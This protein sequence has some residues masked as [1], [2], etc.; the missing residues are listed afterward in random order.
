MMNIS[1][2]T[3]RFC[4]LSADYDVRMNVSLDGGRTAPPADQG[5][6]VAGGRSIAD[7]PVDRDQL[8]EDLRSLG[9]RPGQDLLI[10]CSLRRIGPVDGG[11]ATLLDAIRDVAGPAATLVVPAQTTWNS[12]TS[13][14]FRAATAGLDPASYA[15]YVA[16]MPGFDPA[17]TPSSGMG[18]FAEYVRTRPG[19]CRSAHPQ[20][21][22]AA[23]GPRAAAAMSEHDLDCHFG[24]RSPLRWLYDADAAILLL[25]VDY[26]ACTAFHLAEYRLPRKQMQTYCCFTVSGGTRTAHEFTDIDLD[27]SDF[28]LIG[29]VLNTATW[30][31][32]DDAP[33]SGRVGM[34]ACTLVH[35]R[36]AV[37]FACSWMNEHR[38]ISARQLHACAL[39]PHRSIVTMALA[40]MGGRW[41]VRCSIARC[42][43]SPA[44][45]PQATTGTRWWSGSTATPAQTLPRSSSCRTVPTWESWTALDC[46]AA[47][48][49]LLNQY[50]LSVP[51]GCLLPC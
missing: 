47:S 29:T 21:S 4:G 33:R 1:R 19:A 46:G 5:G 50:A 40:L 17:T 41:D 37:D 13:R 11:A 2:T 10:H 32:V 42:R 48:A 27:D 16:A 38:G 28:G 18:A 7:G 8:A 15:R 49:G 6:P 34:A 12:F 31:D 51:V 39:Y 23:I 25:G 3:E 26:S 9:L 43:F 44:M 30:P 20:S 45:R 35:M 36:T 24:D 14:V 22:F